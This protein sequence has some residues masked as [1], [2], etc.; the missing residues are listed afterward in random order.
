[1]AKEKYLDN[2]KKEEVAEYVAHAYEYTRSNAKAALDA[3]NKEKEISDKTEKALK[4]VIEKFVEFSK[5][6]EK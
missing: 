3:I 5:K 2:L 1:M 6:E 4:E